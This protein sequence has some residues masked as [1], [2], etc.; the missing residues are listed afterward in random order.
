MAATEAIIST[1]HPGYLQQG[2]SFVITKTCAKSLLIRMNRN[3]I[4]EATF[5]LL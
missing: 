5:R 4:K 2:G 1:W 3:N